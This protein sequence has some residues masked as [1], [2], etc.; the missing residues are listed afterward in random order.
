MITPRPLL[1]SVFG[2]LLSAAGGLQAADVV[3]SAPQNISGDSDVSTNGTSYGAVKIGSASVTSA[4]VNGVTFDPLEFPYYS[5][6]AQSGNLHF[7]EDP[8]YLVNY[9]NLGTNSGPFASL[10]AGYQTLLGSGGGSDNFNTISLFISGLTIGNTYE[11]QWWNNNSNQ[12]TS[13]SSGYGLFTQASDQSGNTQALNDNV[14]GTVGDLGQF[15]IGMFLADASTQIVQFNGAFDP[16]TGLPSAPMLNALQVR[17]ITVVPEPST[18]AT[19]LAGFGVLALNFR[20]RKTL[21]S[22]AA[23]AFPR[24]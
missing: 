5:T 12:V 10:S 20:M 2:F 15:G 8:G 18:V 14:G 3:W 7:N 24:A 4:T 21:R 16:N 11:I 9:D 22:L 1:L 6:S 17:D 19:V 23:A 13:P